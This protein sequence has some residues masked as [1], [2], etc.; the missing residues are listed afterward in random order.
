MFQSPKSGKF[1]SNNEYLGKLTGN[2][3]QGSNPL[4]RGNLNQIY[5]QRFE[6]DDEMIA[7]FQSPKSGKFESN[8]KTELLQLDMDSRVPIP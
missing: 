5:H 7:K 2:N 1:E 8:V 3:L 4:N 6:R